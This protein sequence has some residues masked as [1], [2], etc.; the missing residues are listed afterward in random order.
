[1]QI[2]Y[3]EAMARIVAPRF[4][5]ELVSGEHPRPTAGIF[6]MPLFTI[7]LQQ[8]QR[9]NLSQGRYCTSSR[10]DNF[11][12]IGRLVIVPAD[13]PVEI[14]SSGG[15]VQAV[16]CMFSRDM[17]DEY[18]DNQGLLDGEIPESCLNLRHEGISDML[19]R[20]GHE[21]RSP[22]LASAALTEALGTATIIEFIRFLD[23]QPKS[24]PSYRGGLSR[25]QF[26]QIT[27]YIEAPENSPSLTDLSRLT[28]LS[29]RH[30]TRAFKQTTG[31]TVYA[32]IEQVRFEKA[33]A[34]LAETDMLIK[35]IAHRLGFSCSGAFCS[36]F[37]RFGGETPQGYRKRTRGQ[38]CS[39]DFA[40]LN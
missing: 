25:R 6:E 35:T 36:A 15:H 38:C 10:R 4:T 22:G 33:Q 5:T 17:L 8:T 9:H 26:R 16:R 37:R 29:I 23:D 3:N 14:R 40:R 32:H 7:A 34:L 12:D 19:A 27:E 13:V 18:S 1:M 11:R 21:L 24:L 31:T 28:G 30:L 2:T 20:L 39:E